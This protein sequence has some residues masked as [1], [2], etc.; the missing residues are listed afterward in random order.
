MPKTNKTTSYREL[1]DELAKIILWFESGEAD[2]DEALTKYDQA[3]KIIAEIEKYLKSAENRLRKL[4][5][6]LG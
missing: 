2:V 1:N 5:A 3:Q 6:N 4:N